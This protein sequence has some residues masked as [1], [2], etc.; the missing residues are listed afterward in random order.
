MNGYIR[1]DADVE[2]LEESPKAVDPEERQDQEG[3]QSQLSHCNAGEKGTWSV[4]VSPPG[5]GQG[6]SLPTVQP[7]T[8]VKGLQRPFKLMLPLSKC[9]DTG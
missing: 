3:R 4:S 6:L 9:E 2:A 8:R 7:K 1:E 5:L